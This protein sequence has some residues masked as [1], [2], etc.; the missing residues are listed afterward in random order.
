MQQEVR[1]KPLSP[2]MAI[3][4]VALAIAVL[5]GASLICS[6]LSDAI[7]GASATIL[8]YGSGAAVA[9]YLMRTHVMRYLYTYNGLVVRIER[10]YGKRPRFV[11][12]I[13]LRKIKAVGALD[14]VKAKNP[15]AKIVRATHRGCPLAEVAVAYQG[16]QGVRIALIQPDEDML[17]KILEGEK[18]A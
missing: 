17:A 13:Q 14:E 15:G 18:K 9:V 1:G 11:E 2:V 5:L 6:L 3:L 10:A 7:G 8:F 12:D 4:T 16:E